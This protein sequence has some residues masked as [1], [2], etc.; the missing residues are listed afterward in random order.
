MFLRFM[1][2]KIGDVPQALMLEYRANKRKERIPSPASKSV[3]AAKYD[4]A[5]ECYHLP[6]I[7]FTGRVE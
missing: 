1:L 6:A 4:A 2:A 7:G 5:I 3:D